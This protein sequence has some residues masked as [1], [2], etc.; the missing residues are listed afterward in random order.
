MNAWFPQTPVKRLTSVSLDL[1]VARG[2]A[3]YGKVRRG[4]GVAIGGGLPRTYYL[5]I[6]VKDA[7]GKLEAKH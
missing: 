5:K 4:F 2:A 6:D 3:Y 1:A 7:S